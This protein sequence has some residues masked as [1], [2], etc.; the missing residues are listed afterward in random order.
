MKFMHCDATKRRA[1]DSEIVRALSYSGSSQRINVLH[2][3][4]FKL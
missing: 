2:Q 1:H 3:G 4:R